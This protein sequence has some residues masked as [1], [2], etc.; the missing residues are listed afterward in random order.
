MK[1]N[2][3]S[4][5]RNIS[6]A[7]MYSFAQRSDTQVIDEPF[8]GYY[9]ATTDVEHPGR[10]EVLHSMLTDTGSILEQIIFAPQQKPV[11]FI[12]NMAHHLIQ[13]DVDFLLRL[14]NVFLIRDPKKLIA[15]FAEVIPA[16]TMSDIG[17]RRQYEL[18]RF[19]QDKTGQTPPVL[20]AEE[21]LKNPKSILSRL[22]DAIQIPFE[23]S[24]LSWKAGP[25]KEDGIWAKYWYANV[26][27][28]T[29]FERRESSDRT[30]PAQ[31][32]TLYEEALPFYR[33][34]NQYALKA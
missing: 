30:L 31:C 12:K 23:E 2:L 15:S 1:I 25:L 26:H 19:L 24:M 8:Y 9:L 3:I 20:N 7:L 34:L 21:V 14:V 32:R 11:L 28:S 27:Q 10:E 6:T 29:G 13:G 4:G 33:E 16:P 22:C 17:V 18:F 5:P